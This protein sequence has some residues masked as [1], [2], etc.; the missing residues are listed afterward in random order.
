MS[1]DNLAINE[2]LLE[3]I[4]VYLAFNTGAKNIDKQKTRTLIQQL[5]STFMGL[6]GRPCQPQFRLQL[7][8]LFDRVDAIERQLYIHNFSYAACVRDKIESKAVDKDGR[9]KDQEDKDKDIEDDGD[10]DNDDDAKDMLDVKVEQNGDEGDNGKDD[11]DNGDGDQDDAKIENGDDRD[12]FDKIIDQKSEDS[13]KDQHTRPMEYTPHSEE[14]L[15]RASISDVVDVHPKHN[16]TRKLF[17]G[18]HQFYVCFRFY[19]TLFERLLK[20][21]ELARDLPPNKNTTPMA[22]EEREALISH[23]YESF[24][25]IL[26]MYLAETI[27]PAVYEDCLRCIYG[28]D[29]GFLF[30]LDKI[31]ANFTRSLPSDELSTFVL[32]HSREL[33]TLG[34]EP[35][36][37]GESV[38][39]A[40][41]SFKVR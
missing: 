14:S 30:S 35:A 13:S 29:A 27:E 2:D 26:K 34:E 19:Y 20:A 33:F 12:S 23:R 36:A 32:D 3:I 37:V 40:Q 38:K 16:S 24:K 39:Y 8:G 31:L 41:I 22:R 5:I 10:A 15:Q 7:D 4:E 11:D 6:H 28:R 1:M 17:Y 21:S 25:E 9:P 18:G